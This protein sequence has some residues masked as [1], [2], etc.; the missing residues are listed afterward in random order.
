[1]PNN[2]FRPDRERDLIAELA[3]LIGQAYPRG[4]SAPADNRFREETSSDGYEVPSELPLAPQLQVYGDAPEQTSELDEHYDDDGAYDV[5]D[6]PCADKEYRTE[7]PRVRRRSLA[8][9]IAMTGLALLGTAGAFGYREMLGGSVLPTPPPIITASNEPNKLAPASSAPQAKNSGNARQGDEVTT[10]SIEKLVP[11]EEQPATIE[12]SK[13]AP[14]SSSHRVGAPPTAGQPLPNQATPHVV[15]ASDPP[16]PPPNA[17]AL[18]HGGQSGAANGTAGANHA[19]L[20]AAPIAPAEANSAA[21]ATPP[22][23][24]RGYAVQ[25]TSER[26]ESG[27]QAAFRGLKAKYPNQ[28]RGRQPIIRRADLGAAGIYYRALVGPFA[29]TE[30]AAKLCSEL[31]AT[32]GDCIILKN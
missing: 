7:V 31:K 20:A 29:S 21:A 23:L 19:H 13:A 30:K 32:G 25:V 11:R 10:G 27:A 17:V 24:G 4:Q 1:M 6:Q 15:A 3:R 16:G 22:V 18:Q 8:L 26:S 9:M 2:S 28:L 5:D 12:P 14:R